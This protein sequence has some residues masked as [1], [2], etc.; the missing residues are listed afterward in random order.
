MTNLTPARS[1]LSGQIERL[2]DHDAGD[3]KIEYA[4]VSCGD[5][6]RVLERLCGESR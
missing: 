3:P 1:L 2:G 6:A 4:R 5:L